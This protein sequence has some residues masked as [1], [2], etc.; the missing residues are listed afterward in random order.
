MVNDTQEVQFYLELVVKYFPHLQIR[1][2][3]PIQA[4][5]SSF[6]LDINGEYIFRFPRRPEI[7]LLH[8]HELGLLP[9][10]AKWLPVPVPKIEFICPPGDDRPFGFHGYRKIQGVPMTSEALDSSASLATQLGEFLTA[11]HHFPNEIAAQYVPVYTTTTWREQY[12]E[13]YEWVREKLFPILD[14]SMRIKVAA[15]WEDH[16][17]NETSFSFQPALIHR[18]LCPEDHIYCDPG[19]QTLT[20][21]IDWEDAS[22]GDPAM[23]FV[24]LLGLGGRPFVE[25]VLSAYQGSLGASFWHRAAFYLDIGPFHELR[26]ALTVQDQVHLQ[27]GLKNVYRRFE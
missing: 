8:V 16:L 19:Y 3:T 21:V 20:G 5:W 27:Q 23:D 6:V 11:L 14:E 2:A 12:V 24:G 4:G 26:F 9:E 13:F 25:K 22:I 1:T 7:E 15:F 10:L 17:K 18:D